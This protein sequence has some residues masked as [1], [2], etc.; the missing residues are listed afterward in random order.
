MRKARFQIASTQTEGNDLD[1]A[2]FRAAVPGGVVGDMHARFCRAGRGGGGS[3]RHGANAAAER[4]QRGTNFTDDL[5]NSRVKRTQI[6]SGHWRA[7]IAWV[8]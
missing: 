1:I 7:T 3:G 2:L 6:P 4:S 8:R 5:G